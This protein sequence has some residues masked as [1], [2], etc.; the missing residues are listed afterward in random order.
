MAGFPYGDGTVL[1]TLLQN[2]WGLGRPEAGASA[3]MAAVSYSGEAL[4]H[5]KLGA[6]PAITIAK[7]TLIAAI[8]GGVTAFL[9]W[10]CTA[11]GAPTAS[12]P[13]SR[14]ASGCSQAGTNVSRGGAPWWQGASS[15]F[16]GPGSPP[17][18]RTG[19]P[20]GRTPRGATSSTCS[21]RPSGLG[22]LDGASDPDPRDQHAL[23]G[24][25]V[26]ALG[27]CAARRGALRAVLFA[28]RPSRWGWA[29]SSWKATGSSRGARRFW[30]ILLAASGVLGQALRSFGRGQPKKPAGRTG[31]GLAAHLVSG[32][33]ASLMK[34]RSV[35][36]PT[37]SR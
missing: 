29:R 2:G 12:R 37:P 18:G 25:A 24:P 30:V 9:A 17:F 34:A 26:R 1:S 5:V 4:E 27:G 32:R 16:S 7:Y 21:S 36:K 15:G 28:L 10:I 6:S 22:R 13:T 11:L 14:M 31:R 8:A 23:H 33:E 35:G 20:W 19:I 3:P